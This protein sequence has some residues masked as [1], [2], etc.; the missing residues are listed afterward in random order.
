MN[1]L[2]AWLVKAILWLRYRVRITGLGAV[3]ARGRSGILF[4][5]NHPGLIDPVIVTSH[6]YGP[7]KVRA[8]ADRRQIDRFFIRWLA[9]RIGVLPIESLADAGAAAGQEVRRTIAAVADALRKGD[10]IILYPAGRAYQ[11]R[12]EDLGGA[13]AVQTILK[14]LPDVRVVLIRT[15]GL[16]GSA[17][18]RA[19]GTEPDVGRIVRRGIVTFLLNGIFFGPRRRVDITMAEPDDLPRSADRRTLNRYLE[20]F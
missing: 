4:L 3:T 2:L 20:T 16:W 18:T 12:L 5:P 1:R 6:L 8:L 9:R 14:E 11:S 15:R 13:S 17:F 10:N 7:F 19:S